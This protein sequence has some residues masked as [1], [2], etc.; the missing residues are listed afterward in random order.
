[1]S[2][3]LTRH[4]DIREWAASRAGNPALAETPDG[5]SSRITLQIVF[6]QYRL[7]AEDEPN[8]E[9]PGALE[10]VN[11]DD[12]F[13]EFDKQKLALKV[14]DEAPGLFDSDHEFVAR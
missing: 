11:W 14:D 5:S 4:S 1:M 13:A 10:L 6:D 7:N 9:R 8:N 12:W 2:K 3:L